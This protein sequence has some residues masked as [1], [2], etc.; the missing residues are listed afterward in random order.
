MSCAL[1]LTAATIA[2]AE[3]Y[4]VWRRAGARESRAGATLLHRPEVGSQTDPLPVIHV[5]R[6]ITGGSPILTLVRMPLDTSRT[7]TRRL[8]AS[9]TS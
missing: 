9:P 7:L 5:P 1:A 3:I 6:E 8:I 2:A 4:V